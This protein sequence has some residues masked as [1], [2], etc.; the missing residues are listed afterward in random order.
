MNELLWYT[1]RATGTASIVLLTGVVVLG[2]AISGRGARSRDGATIVTALHRWLS[3][4][5]T[6]FLLLHV[7]TAVVETYVSIDLIS[8]ILPFTSGYE[9]LWVGLGT[10][11]FDLFVAV[12]VTSLLRQ[13]IS[14]RTWRFVHWAAYLLWPLAILHGFTLGTADEPVLRHTTHACAVAG[15]AAIVWRSG[16]THHDT[17][18]RRDIAAQE[19]S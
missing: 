11:A 10:L 13:R 16:V 15:G 19:W 18:R 5:M 12:V 14:D 1:S 6:V 2:A 9:R 7:A 3:L 4:G 17:H 8:A